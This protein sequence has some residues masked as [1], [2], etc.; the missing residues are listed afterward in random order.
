MLTLQC[1]QFQWYT[2]YLYALLFQNMGFSIIP[3]FTCEFKIILLP[4]KT[5]FIWLRPQWPCF[6]HA[7][8]LPLV[9]DAVVQIL[10]ALGLRLAWQP[11]FSPVSLLSRRALGME[12]GEGMHPYSL[13]LTHASLIATCADLVCVLTAS[14]C[15]QHLAF[16]RLL[17]HLLTSLVC[18]GASSFPFN[19]LFLSWGP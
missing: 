15:L 12:T 2:P 18:N 11:M 13:T 19:L 4:N 1:S 5:L 8:S 16:H 7:R 6:Y 14:P 9:F 17:C 3:Y 10:T